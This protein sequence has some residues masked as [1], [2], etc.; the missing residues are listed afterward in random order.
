MRPRTIPTGTVDDLRASREAVLSELAAGDR[1][2]LAFLR[3]PDPTT[4]AIPLGDLLSHAPGLDEAV[5]ARVLHLAH[6]P[7]SKRVGILSAQEVEAVCGWIKDLAPEAWEQWRR[8]TLR[9]YADRPALEIVPDPDTAPPAVD[10]PSCEA[11]IERALVSYAE[12]GAALR[13]IRDQG[14]YKQGYSTFEEYCRERWRWSKSQAYRQIDAAAV[15]ETIERSPIGD[16]P[17]TP[18]RNEATARELVPFRSKPAQLTKIWRLVVGRHGPGAQA[19]HVRAVVAEILPTTAPE[20]APSYS[21]D[22]AVSALRRMTA[23]GYDL[24]ILR[25]ALDAID[26]KRAAA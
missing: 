7:W 6:L 17:A 20:P 5:V 15:Y 22:D 11:T 21:V 23:R 8:A 2:L 14:L 12:A 16:A 18:P 24:A 13:A 4:E 19:S 26:E 10:L 1:H 9:D 3:E 25:Q